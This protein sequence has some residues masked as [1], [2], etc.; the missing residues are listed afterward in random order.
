MRAAA[1]SVLFF[2]GA[3]APAPAWGPDGHR[4][5]CA[6]AW[7][8]MSEPVRAKAGAL[9]GLSEKSAFAETCTR[10]DVPTETASSHRVFVPKAARAIDPAR[11]CA[12]G[13]AL[14]EIDRGIAVLRD[15]ADTA[16][17]AQALKTLGHL[18]AD[19]HQPLN[20]AFTEDDGG[21]RVKG[22]FRGAPVT[23]RAMW[24]TEMIATLRPPGAHDGLR[25]D[26][27]SI[28]GRAP[29]TAASTPLDW[30]N[31]TLW[32]MRAPATGYLGA[33]GGIDYDDTYLRQNRRV[34]LEQLD[35][36]GVRLAGLLTEVL[37][38]T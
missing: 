11:D 23:L 16:A 26:F 3:T 29:K 27:M 12:K 24:E 1:L 34:A 17:K 8:E 38:G 9:L 35:K 37:G 18:V 20:I 22:T 30:A 13:C 15:S 7:D 10:L 5:A 36:A 31:E 2:I 6:I 32:I 28:A 25:Y 33:P 4:I 14:A 21:A 19:I